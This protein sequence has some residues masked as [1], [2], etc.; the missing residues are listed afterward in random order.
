MKRGSAPAALPPTQTLRKASAR[1][2]RG[3]AAEEAVATW[4]TER[5][6]EIVARNLRIGH[7]EIDLLARQRELVVIVEVRTRGV[8]SWT[9]AFGSLD[10][11]KR[12]RVRLAGERLWQRRYARDTSVERLRFDAA[13]VTFVDGVAHVE[14]VA[15]AF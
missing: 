9:T 11:G 8:G 6:F 12:R 13:S 1:Q 5:D 15:A 14:Y 2:Q 10:P 7:Y 3:R 4:L